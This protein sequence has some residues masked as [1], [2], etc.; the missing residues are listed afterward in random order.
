MTALSTGGGM[1]EVIE[2]D[3]ASVSMMGD[4]A[5]TLIYT[6]RPGSVQSLLEGAFTFDDI[7]YREGPKPFVE[8][9]SQRHPDASLLGELR[10][11]DGVIDIALVHPVM[12]VMAR[13][14]LTVPFTNC[15]EMLEHD[16]GEGRPLWELAVDYESARGDID[17]AEVFEKMRAIIRIMGQAIETGMRGTSYEDRILGSQAPGFRKKME[18]GALVKGDL[19]KPGPV[20]VRVH[21]VSLHADLLGIGTHGE[22]HMNKARCQQL[23]KLATGLIGLLTTE[24]RQNGLAAQAGQQSSGVRRRPPPARRCGSAA[25]ADPRHPRFHAPPTSRRVR[26]A[27]CGCR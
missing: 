9:R 24:H 19:S 15:A 23:I 1:I 16:G 2:V 3:G 10:S 11:L 21:A 7:L 5:E 25:P 26:R 13:R 12:P 27:P 14:D 4:Y 20:L 8:L 18:S 17:R 6:D 22:L